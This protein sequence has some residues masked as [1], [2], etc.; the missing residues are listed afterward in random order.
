MLLAERARIIAAVRDD[1]SP[2]SNGH[3][4]VHP[5]SVRRLDGATG[6]VEALSRFLEE[7]RRHAS[8]R[9]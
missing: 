2:G 9:S 5:E 7:C 4:G 8:R 1:F 6:Q 3:G